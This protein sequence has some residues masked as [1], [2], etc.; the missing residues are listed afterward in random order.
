MVYVDLNPFRAKVAT[1]LKECLFTSILHRIKVIK[2]GRHRKRRGNRGS[3][4]TRRQRRVRGSLLPIESI[5]SMATKEYV[6]LVADAGGVAGDS[7]DHTDRLSALGIDAGRWHEVMTQ[8]AGCLERRS[9]ARRSWPRKPDAAG[10]DESL[11][12]WTSIDSR[13]HRSP[14]TLTR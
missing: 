7:V 13:A 6:S 14:D 4:K 5:L 12:P 2:G 1:T 3:A 10:T 9:A 8:T 11:T